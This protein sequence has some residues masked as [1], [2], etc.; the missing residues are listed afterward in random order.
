MILR[1]PRSTRTDTLFPYTTL[2]RSEQVAADRL[3]RLTQ[4]GARQLDGGREGADRL[5][6]AEH[7]GLEVAIQVHQRRAVVLRDALGRDARDLSHH[8]LDVLYG[9]GLL[10]LRLRQQ[11]L[12]SADLVD[13][14][15]RLVGA[16]AVADIACREIGRAHV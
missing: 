6:L 1:P 14:V 2:F 13:H 7:H 4:A 11:A 5:V 15:A 12:R 8:R 16:L 9:D 10:A 3:L